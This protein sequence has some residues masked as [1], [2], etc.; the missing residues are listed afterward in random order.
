MLCAEGFAPARIGLEAWLE[1]DAPRLEGLRR[2]HELLGQLA[3][4]LII[5]KTLNHTRAIKGF[6]YDENDCRLATY[7]VNAATHLDT[8]AIDVCTRATNN[9]SLLIDVCRLDERRCRV[10]MSLVTPREA[11]DTPSTH[12]ATPSGMADGLG[13]G[14]WPTGWLLGGGGGA[15]GRGGV[16]AAGQRLAAG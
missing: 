2:V 14:L 16:G 4:L 15:A 12:L 13:G 5:V 11:F 8:A 6:Y 1:G 10:A 3:K 9:C 7:L